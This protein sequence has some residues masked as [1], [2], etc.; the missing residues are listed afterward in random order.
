MNLRSVSLL[1][2]CALGL[3]AQ[4]GYNLATRAKAGSTQEYTAKAEIKVEGQAITLTGKLR[5]KIDKIDAERVTMTQT[6]TIEKIEVGEEKMDTEEKIETIMETSPLGDLLGYRGDDVT[7]S[8]IREASASTVK[9]QPM[10]NVGDKWTFEVKETS[11]WH[12]VPVKVT[13]EAVAIETVAGI[14][15]MRIKFAGKE[16][17]GSKPIESNGEIWI[18]VE[19]GTMTKLVETTKNATV[20]DGITGESSLTLERIAA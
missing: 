10:T 12:P 9:L 15:S 1:T 18:S 17:E 11:K 8:D 5:N 4:T 14:K 13:Y 2:V 6:L 16:L 3:W 19:D 20:D 7:D